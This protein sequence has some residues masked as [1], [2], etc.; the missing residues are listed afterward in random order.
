MG[1]FAHTWLGPIETCLNIYICIY[2]TLIIYA[3]CAEKIL[4]LC[5]TCDSRVNCGP[6]CDTT[7][8]CEKRD[9]NC[10]GVDPDVNLR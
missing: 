8:E 4:N 10:C 1:V 7:V 2:N 3:Q 6:T 9:V 5:V